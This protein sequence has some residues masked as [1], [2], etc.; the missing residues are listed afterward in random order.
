MLT[1]AGLCGILNI[2]PAKNLIR[3][4]ASGLRTV[5]IRD[6]YPTDTILKFGFSPGRISGAKVRVNFLFAVVAVALIWRL[7]SFEYGLLATAI[8]LFS[9]LL[10]EVAHLVVARSTGG[11]MDELDLWPLGGLSEPFGR[12]YWRDHVQTMLAGPL[13]NALLAASCLKAVV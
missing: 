10:H 13:I 3:P 2:E 5:T 4:L 9:V 7:N 6:M 12:G 8:L 11:E 1:T